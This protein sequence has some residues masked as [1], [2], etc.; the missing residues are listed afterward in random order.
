M[1]HFVFHKRIHLKKNL[2]NWVKVWRRALS[3]CSK[4]CFAHA[5]AL[6][7]TVHGCPR[8]PDGLADRPVFVSDSGQKGLQQQSLPKRWNLPQPSRFLFLYL[9]FTVE[10]ES[11]AFG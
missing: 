1:K 9:P 3:D 7:R 2:S 6:K 11:L 4:M 5:P 10:G 8:R